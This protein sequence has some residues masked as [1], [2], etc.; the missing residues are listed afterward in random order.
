MGTRRP[1]TRHLGFGL[2]DLREIALVLA[3]KVKNDDE[4]HPAIRGHAGKKLG[5]RLDSACRCAEPYDGESRMH[6]G[7]GHVVLVWGRDF[8]AEGKK[9]AC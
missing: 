2:E 5:E 1:R 9:T 4:G 3:G 8:K 7:H 6:G